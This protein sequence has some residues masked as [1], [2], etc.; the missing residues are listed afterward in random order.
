MNK[1]LIAVS[2]N[3]ELKADYTERTKKLKRARKHQ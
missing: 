3:E 2:K 1:M